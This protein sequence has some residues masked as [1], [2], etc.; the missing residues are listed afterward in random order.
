MSKPTLGDV[1]LDLATSMKSL[2]Y[3]AP[4]FFEL[5]DYLVEPLAE[6]KEAVT[7]GCFIKVDTPSPSYEQQRRHFLFSMIWLTRTLC[8]RLITL[9]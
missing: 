1:V 4:L 8:I 9:R 2:R 3:E 7:H 5:L 6:S